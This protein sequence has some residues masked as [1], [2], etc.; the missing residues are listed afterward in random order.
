MTAQSYAVTGAYGVDDVV[1]HSTF[2]LGFVLEAT[3]WNR[4]KV[5]FQDAERTLIA[6]HG[7]KP[8]A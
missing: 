8:Q 5:I 6:R 1:E 4:I 3:A 2:G 7:Q